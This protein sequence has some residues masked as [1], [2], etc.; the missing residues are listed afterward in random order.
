MDMKTEEEKR[1]KEDGERMGGGR[2]RR[3][4]REIESSIRGR[5]GRVLRVVEDIQGT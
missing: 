5:G 1:D 4:K 3:K 2:I